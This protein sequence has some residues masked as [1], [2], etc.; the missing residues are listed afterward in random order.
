MDEFDHMKDRLNASEEVVAKYKRK[1]EDNQVLLEQFK[2]TLLI[3]I[4]VKYIFFFLIKILILIFYLF[5]CLFS[6][7]ST[8]KRKAKNIPKVFKP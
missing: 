2:V 8:Y 3:Y 1:L 7:Y 4:F 6:F 5:I